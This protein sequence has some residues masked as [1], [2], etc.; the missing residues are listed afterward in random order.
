MLNTSCH[1]KSQLF[2][3]E[4]PGSGSRAL[5]LILLGVTFDH[6]LW[7]FYNLNCFEILQRKFIKIILG[8]NKC[9]P[10]VMV[11]GE[12]GVNPISQI[13]NMRMINFYMKII[14]GKQSKF[15]CIMYQILRKQF[16]LHDVNYKWI[17]HVKQKLG[18]CGMLDLWNFSGNGFT[19]KYV[20]EAVKLRIKDISIQDWHASKVDHAYCSFYD[21]V[22]TR[23]QTRKNISQI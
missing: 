20:K 12:S 10:N 8:V 15:S 16:E 19:N 5:D 11:Y 1:A 3:V 22:K 4:I 2:V 9:T 7:G 6:P 18:N 17:D 13:V 14:N 21:I 23:L